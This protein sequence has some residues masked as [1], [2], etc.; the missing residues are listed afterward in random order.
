MKI[1]SALLTQMSGSIGGMTGA[2]NRGGLYLRARTIPV[3]TATAF[4]NQVRTGFTQLVNFWTDVL[5]A[6]QRASWELYAQ[7]VLVTDSLGDPRQISGQ[8]WYIGANTPRLQANAKLGTE[9]TV[10][11]TAP[12]SF[13]RGEQPEY[14]ISDFSAATG[15]A[16]SFPVAD[17]PGTNVNAA[18]LL[19]MGR[20]RNAGRTFFKGPWRLVA[21]VPGAVAE[22]DTIDVS[23]AQASARG[24][25][26][27][28]GQRVQLVTA[29]LREDGRFTSRTVI[30]DDLVAVS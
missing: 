2:H 26:L 4:Q 17:G 11:N 25:P 15:I 21:A 8:N 23:P 28:A 22:P 18:I 30:A 14:T 12:N 3:D 7:N 16:I 29:M 13:N 5:T 20:P 27:V 1:K 19:F 6:S 24:W 10:V 9:L